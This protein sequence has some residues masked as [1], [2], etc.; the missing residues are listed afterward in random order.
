MEI[1]FLNESSKQFDRPTNVIDGHV[2]TLIGRANILQ[3]GI[4]ECF[5][6][7]GIVRIEKI[8]QK[9]DLMRLEQIAVDREDSR[10]GRRAQRISS[11]KLFDRH[12]D[13]SNIP[14]VVT[15]DRVEMFAEECRSI[16]HGKESKQTRG[17]R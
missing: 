5:Q 13:L 16:E 17:G 12:L 2:G 15:G 6:D 14:R 4:E 11:E 1:R 8:E 3:Q 9:C 7:I 10:R